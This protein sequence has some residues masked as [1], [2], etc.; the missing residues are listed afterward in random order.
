M[1][2][3]PGK[4][5][6]FP[7]AHCV[8]AWLRSQPRGSRRQSARRHDGDLR[9]DEAAQGS[10]REE[11]G[12]DLTILPSSTSRGLTDLAQGRADIAML[13]EPLESAAESI[14]AKQPGAVKAEDLV[15]KHVGNAYV[16]F[17]VHPSNPV[18]TQQGAA[19]G[20]VQRQ[21]QELVRGRRGNQPVL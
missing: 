13:A 4:T 21:D 10:D 9:P 12:A 7:A 11:A 20:S 1:T 17:I 16:Q 3:L 18:K 2:F 19:R 15:G 6:I 8:H 14:N 5:G